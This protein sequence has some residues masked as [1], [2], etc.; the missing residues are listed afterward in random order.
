MPTTVTLNEQRV[1]HLGL[2]YDAVTVLQTVCKDAKKLEQQIYASI[3]TKITPYQTVLY[4]EVL[5]NILTAPPD[6]RA[7]LIQDYTK[8]Q[9]EFI[10]SCLQQNKRKRVEE[11]QP[12]KKCKVESDSRVI[13]TTKVLPELQKMMAKVKSD[14][15]DCPNCKTKEF[16]VETPIQTRSGDEAATVFP[17]CTKC[18]EIVT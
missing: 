9:P 1:Q 5:A 8:T 16:M 12:V 7:K 4:K 11:Q 13:F 14:L 6:L 15:P 18:K 10:R 3:V 2:R 17:Q